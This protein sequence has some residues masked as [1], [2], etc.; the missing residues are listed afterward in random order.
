[1]IMKRVNGGYVY[2]KATDMSMHEFTIYSIVRGIK[3][4]SILEIGI[5]AGVSTH[6]ICCALEDEFT[7]YS[8][9]SYNCCDIDSKC[10]RVQKLTKIP[11]KFYFMSSDSLA[12]QWRDPI[13]LLFIDGCHEYN[14]VKRDYFNFTQYVRKNGFVFLHDTNPVT[15]KDKSPLRCWN[16]YK[17]IDD[18]KKDKRV[19]YVTLPYSYGLT[20]C[21]KIT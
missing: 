10:S 4:K 5:K 7:R 16:A 1:M 9:I 14:Q 8:A 13:D 11:L 20:I 2:S 21:R 3:P 6:A 15:M 18:I 19:E 17:I 12:K